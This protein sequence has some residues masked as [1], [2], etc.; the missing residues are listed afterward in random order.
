VQ[1]HDVVVGDHFG[2]HSDSQPL[3]PRSVGLDFS[4]P[5]S[6]H[7]Y[8]IP[9]HTSPLSL[10]STAA[11]SAN[12]PHHYHE[13]YRLYNLDVFEYELDETMALYGHIPFML[14]HDEV[15]GKGTAAVYCCYLISFPF[16]IVTVLFRVCFGSIHL[17]LL[18]TSLTA[19]LL[20]K[21]EVS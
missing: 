21:T 1:H 17:R 19:Q 10:P 6:G 12:I 5:F 8:G 16:V 13:P 4:F 14:A 11:G 20:L 3:G 9:E 2:G 7:V 18:L 15:N